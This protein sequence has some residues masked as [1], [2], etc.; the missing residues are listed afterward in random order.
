MARLL[1]DTNVLL[2]HVVGSHDRT[3]I[4]RLKRTETFTEED[5]D[6]LQEELA[7]YSGLVV[8]ASVLSEV[9]N[10]LPNWAHPNIAGT[11]PV[12]FA[13]FEELGAAFLTV[14]ADPVFPR[15]GFTDTGIA[16]IASAVTADEAIHVLTDDVHLYNEL[17][18]RGIG[19]TNFNHLRSGR[20]VD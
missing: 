20:M 7:R 6:L 2:L 9:S 18:Y 11:M 15:L 4:G 10:L 17:A 16:T 13:L 14:M 19:V 8:T 12:V 1:V 3:M 5:F